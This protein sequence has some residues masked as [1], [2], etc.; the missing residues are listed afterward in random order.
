MLPCPLRRT[1][2]FRAHIRLKPGRAPPCEQV[3][4]AAFKDL[5]NNHEAYP[6]SQAP[7]HTAK[8][9]GGEDDASHYNNS[10]SGVTGKVGA[11]GNNYSRPEGQNVRS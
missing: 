3:D 5:S 1:S 4:P 2:V 7:Y 6:G 8:H 10:L 9:H 11:G